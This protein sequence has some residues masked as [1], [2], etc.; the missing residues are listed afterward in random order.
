[1]FSLDPVR[2]K[3]DR[4][5][6]NV[7]IPVGDGSFVLANIGDNVTALPNTTV[8]V[9]CHASGT[10]K[11]FVR[12]MKDGQPLTSDDDVM[13]ES[14]GILTLPSVKIRDKGRYTCTVENVVGKDTSSSQ[15]DVVCKS[16]HVCGSFIVR[17]DVEEGVLL[18]VTDVSTTCVEVIFRVNNIN[19]PLHG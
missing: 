7:N 13:I 2:A 18:A 19:S 1:M 5:E 8:R 9:T 10:P 4:P 15:V 12:W 14:D 11:P 16:E 3:I 6:K 17:V